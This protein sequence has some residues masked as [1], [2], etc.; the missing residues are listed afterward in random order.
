MRRVRLLLPVAAGVLGLLAGVVTALV[1][2]DDPDGSVPNA[3][4]LHLGIPLVNLDC[5]GDSLLLV[6]QGSSSP[7]LIAAVA[8][9]PELDLHYL[10]PDESC[11]T[12]YAPQSQGVP[13]Y[14]VYAGPYDG[15]PEPCELRMS[16]EHQGDT[17]TNLTSGNDSFVKCLCAL[18]VSAFPELRPGM[19][20]D[21]AIG[22]YVRSLQSLLVD[23]DNQREIDGEDGPFFKITD[24][25]GVYDETTQARIED[26]QDEGVVLPSERGSVLFTT[27]KTLTDDTCKLYDF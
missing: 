24:V 4:P 15:M 3:D 19:E 17:V 26:Y 25:T 23:L 16:P 8:N 6:A 1:A 2:A 21:P 10:R 7:P 27:W 14:A 13:D 5:T 18:P 9:N 12:L 11:D 20:P 22:N